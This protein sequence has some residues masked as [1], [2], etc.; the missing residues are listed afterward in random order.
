MMHVKWK[1]EGIKNGKDIILDENNANLLGY[2][3][4]Y[5]IIFSKVQSFIASFFT[6]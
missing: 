4:G 5:K 3:I 1:K 2:P 6:P